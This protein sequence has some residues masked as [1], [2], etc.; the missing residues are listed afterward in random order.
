MET[1]ALILRLA[2]LAALFSALAILAYERKKD[3]KLLKFLPIG[4]RLSTG[5]LT[6]AIFLL[7]Y[8][9]YIPNFSIDYVFSRTSLATPLVYRISA[10]WAGQE[11]SLLFWAWMISLSSLLISE[12][13]GWKKQFERRTQVVILLGFL[14]FL[15]MAMSSSP[16]KL[17]YTGAE[18]VALENKVPLE[19]V[20]GYYGN[21]GLYETGKGFVDGQGMSPSLMSP[22]MALH[23]PLVFAAYG[24]LIVPFAACIIYLLNGKGDWEGLSRRYARCSWL[25]LTSGIALGSFW[26]YEELA[27]GGYWSW[28]PV[29]VSSLIPWLTLTAFLHASIQFRRKKSFRVLA[30]FLALSSMV[31]VIYATF[32]TRSG[33]LKSVHAYSGTAVGNFLLGAVLISGAAAFL[34]SFRRLLSNRKREKKKLR[35][36][37]LTYQTFYLSILL[38][39]VIAL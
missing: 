12:R 16:F 14:F 25:F 13:R 39:F 10:V 1:G 30:P 33:V 3:R 38:L 20:L 7:T 19:A 24:L 6:L 15:A 22:W 29:E 5:L 32:I 26:A 9:F 11:G 37:D 31:L 27:Y 4:V 34:L 17:T 21:L 2:W 23:P 36:S 18:R 8:Y 35:K 28:D